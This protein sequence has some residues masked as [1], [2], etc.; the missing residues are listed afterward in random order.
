MSYT[1][2][3]ALFWLAI[4]ILVVAFIAWPYRKKR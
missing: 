4:V 2:T 1:L 3:M